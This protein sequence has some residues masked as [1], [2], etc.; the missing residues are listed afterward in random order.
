MMVAKCRYDGRTWD[1]WTAEVGG[2][3]RTR[4][5]ALN[6]K[7]GSSG[8]SRPRTVGWNV[9]QMYGCEGG[10]VVLGRELSFDLWSSPATC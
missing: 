10:P 2:R 1:G 9:S 6:S 8:R 4:W 7:V 5:W 3:C